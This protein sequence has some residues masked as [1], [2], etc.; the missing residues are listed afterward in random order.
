MRRVKKWPFNRSN[1]GR[2]SSRTTTSW[3]P[4]SRLAIGDDDLKIISGLKQLEWLDLASTKV[5]DKGLKLLRGLRK[6]RMLHLEYTEVTDEG[7]ARLLAALPD[8]KITRQ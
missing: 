7:V 2:G 4:T 3:A 5:T 1:N 6:L 8:C